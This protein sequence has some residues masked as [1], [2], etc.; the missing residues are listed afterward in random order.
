MDFFGPL[1]LDADVAAPMLARLGS[2][3]AGFSFVGVGASVGLGL[4]WPYLRYD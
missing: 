4:L 2:Y 3:S 1:L